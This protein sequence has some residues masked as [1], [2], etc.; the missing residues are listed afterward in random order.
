MGAFILLYV[1][2]AF[3]D[4]NFCRSEKHVE[5]VRRL[6]LMEQKG[7]MMPQVIDISETHVI[8]NPE[9]AKLTTDSEGG[10]E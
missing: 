2:K 6:E 9:R 7:D 4:P 3:Q 1:I 10:A 5:T 8:A